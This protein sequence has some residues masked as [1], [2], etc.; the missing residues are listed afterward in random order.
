M[1]Y[2][3]LVN[4]INNL[5]EGIEGYPLLLATRT[6]DDVLLE[7]GRLKVRN[8][9]HI[10]K[11]DDVKEL[12]FVPASLVDSENKD[13]SF[14]IKD[15]NAYSNNNLNQIDSYE[16]RCM[17][18]KYENGSEKITLTAPLVG[19]GILYKDHVILLLEDPIEQWQDV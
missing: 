2:D 13:V 5:G 8:I 10:E 4:N 9:S 15:F 19:S 18:L 11:R 7:K 3:E 16:I 14:T 6:V 1:Q 17:D 12:T